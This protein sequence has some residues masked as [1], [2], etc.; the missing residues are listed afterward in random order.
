MTLDHWVLNALQR[1]VAEGPIPRGAW[2]VRAPEGRV[3]VAHELDPEIAGRALYE[4]RDSD[5]VMVVSAEAIRRTG[6]PVP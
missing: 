4:A 5:N 3:R 6:Y 2:F 1:T